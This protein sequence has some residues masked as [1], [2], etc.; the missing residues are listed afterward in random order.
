LLLINYLNSKIT[1]HVQCRLG[2]WYFVFEGQQFSNYFSF[3]SLEAP[4]KEVHTAVHSAL[5]F[6]AAV[7]INEMS[8][9]LYIME[10]S[11]NE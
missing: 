7:D 3:R 9:E 2:K 10:R 6:F 8:Q 4:H 5:N 1:K 11:S